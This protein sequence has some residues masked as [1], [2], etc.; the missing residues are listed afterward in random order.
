MQRTSALTRTGYACRLAPRRPGARHQP[1]SYALRGCSHA[2]LAG[3]KPA[4][5]SGSQVAAGGNRWLLMAVRGH[6][7]GTPAMAGQVPPGRGPG[8][9]PPLLHRTDCCR[10]IRWREGVKGG[11]AC[12]LTGQLMARRVG[13]FLLYPPP[14]RVLVPAISPIGAESIGSG[15]GSM[16]GVAD[17]AATPEAPLTRCL[18]PG[19]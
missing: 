6:L 1:A 2:L 7:G 12:T 10:S 4:L 8:A 11:F 15:A 13:C 3:S 14:G 17:R 16:G 9:P 19:Y 18:R 5:A